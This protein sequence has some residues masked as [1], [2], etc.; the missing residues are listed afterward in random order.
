VGH[1]IKGR[2]NIN[3]IGSPHGMPLDLLD[4]C[5]IITTDPYNEEEIR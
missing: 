3:M 4:R 2:D 1:H 5:L